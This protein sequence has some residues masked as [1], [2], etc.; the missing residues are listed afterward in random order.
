MKEIFPPCDLAVVNEIKLGREGK[1]EKS[2]K[3]KKKRDKSYQADSQ[4]I[5]R[6][7]PPFFLPPTAKLGT[8]DHLVMVLKCGEC[9]MIDE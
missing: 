1:K 9:I 2:G 5:L 6:D 7:P 4:K 3:S 8:C